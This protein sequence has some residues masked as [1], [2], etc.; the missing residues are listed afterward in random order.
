MFRNLIKKFVERNLYEI[1]A[2]ILIENLRDWLYSSYRNNGFMQYYR[3]RK[4]NL[5][6]LLEHGVES[7]EY[8]ITMGRLKEL[9]ELNVNVKRETERRKTKEKKAIIAEA[10]KNKNK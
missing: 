9:G 8:W 10:R 7:K 6:G 3:L 5:L 1:E 4:R 2:P